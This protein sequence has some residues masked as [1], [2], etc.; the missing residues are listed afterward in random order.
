MWCILFKSRKDTRTVFFL[1]TWFWPLSGVNLFVLWISVAVFVILKHSTLRL[2]IWLRE[3]CYFNCRAIYNPTKWGKIFIK[4]EQGRSRNE[5][6]RFLSWTSEQNSFA[7]CNESL[8]TWETSGPDVYP[9]MGC[10][11]RSLTIFLSY[12]EKN[13][14]YCVCPSRGGPLQLC[15]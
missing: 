13:A 2:I 9:G 5:F 14:G 10:H 4:C 8:V 3:H 1:F 12:P 11:E 7:E 6:T 15:M